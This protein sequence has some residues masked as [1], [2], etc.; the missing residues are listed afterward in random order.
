MLLYVK[1]IS[2]N[3]K[4]EIWFNGKW[5]VIEHK[6]GKEITYPASNEQ[7]AIQIFNKIN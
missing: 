7:E 5:K 4:A 1:I 3:E 2:S 6:D